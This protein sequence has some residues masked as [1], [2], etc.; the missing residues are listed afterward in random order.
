M[1]YFTVDI[2]RALPANLLI[3][4]SC[5]SRWAISSHLSMPAAFSWRDTCAPSLIEIENNSMR[6]HQWTL[7]TGRLWENAK[8]LFEKSESSNEKNN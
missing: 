8:N 6:G 5:A 1:E 4:K 3:R 7:Y 2:R